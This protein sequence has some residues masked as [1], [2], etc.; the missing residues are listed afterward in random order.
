MNKTTILKTLVGSRAHG[1]DTPESDYDYRGV[2]IVP[3][4]EILKLNAKVKPTSWIEGEN[5]DTA[6]ELGHFLHLA[7][8]SNPS[9]LE[10]LASPVVEETPLGAK[11]RGLF[12]HVWNST[13]VYNAF[14]GYSHNQ[15]KKF[16]DDKAGRTWK[17]AVA[18]IRVLL[19]GQELLTDGKMTVKL[20]GVTRELLMRIKEG[21]LSKGHVLDL[22]ENERMKLK[23]AYEYCPD[24]RTNTDAVNEFLLEARKEN[25]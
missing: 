19:M 3:T 11:L 20:E 13:D 1:L 25:W 4:S 18:Y 10:V 15:Q 5:D 2:F 12:D 9:I 17:Y 23:K 22:A 24:K 8:R 21:K 16:L 7:T 14:Y 6:Y